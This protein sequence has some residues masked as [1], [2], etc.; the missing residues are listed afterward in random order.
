M[1]GGRARP[2]FDL[3]GNEAPAG[4]TELAFPVLSWS[5]PDAGAVP[6]RGVP[7][8]GSV[9]GLEVGGP[10]RAPG[11]VGGGVSQKRREASKKSRLSPKR[12]WGLGKP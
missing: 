11:L 8:G 10:S 4:S 1:V 6:A 9:L 7:C 3:V 2:C 12:L 5:Q